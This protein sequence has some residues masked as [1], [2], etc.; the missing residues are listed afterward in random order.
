MHLTLEDFRVDTPWLE[1]SAP[2]SP[3]AISDQI[4]GVELHRLVTHA[5]VRGDL[6]VLLSQQYL[7]DA[8][9]PP[10]V[11]LVTA[12]PGSVRAWVYHKHQS[13]RL[14]FTEGEMRV[15][16]YD[17]RPSSPTYKRLNVIDAGADNPLLLTIPP[18]VIHGVRCRGATD[19][20]FVNMPT[21]A[22]DPTNPD[23]CRIPWDHPGIPCRFA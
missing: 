9:T 7:P 10:H 21:R 22:Y 18:L 13:D 19:T 4:N 14:A 3:F 23:K 20:R 15:V 1:P 16:L 5:D 11:Y 12:K 8:Q 2:L 17:L 6:T